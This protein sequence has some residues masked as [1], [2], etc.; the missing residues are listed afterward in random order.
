MQI[1]MLAASVRA[2]YVQTAA[3]NVW[4]ETVFLVAK[5]QG[6]ICLLRRCDIRLRRSDIFA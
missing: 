6:V 1:V 2:Y 3:V 5:G 4:A